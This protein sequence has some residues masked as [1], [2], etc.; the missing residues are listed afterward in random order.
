MLVSVS[1]LF[2]IPHSRTVDTLPSLKESFSF[3][4]ACVPEKWLISWAKIDRC[5]FFTFSI[6]PKVNYTEK[7]RFHSVFMTTDFQQ[8]TKP[9]VYSTYKILKNTFSF[10]GVLILKSISKFMAINFNII[11]SL[12]VSA[13]LILTI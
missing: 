4:C 2:T 8:T 11:R 7:I 12:N 5:S 1:H 3:V 13:G 9:C 10:V 6:A